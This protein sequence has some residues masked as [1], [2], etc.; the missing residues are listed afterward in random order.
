MP[1]LMPWTPPLLTTPS[2]WPLSFGL[3]QWRT[4]GRHTGWSRP[5]QAAPLLNLPQPHRLQRGLRSQWSLQNPPC[6]T[7]CCASQPSKLSVPWP[8][9]TGASPRN[10]LNSSWPPVLTHQP[11]DWGGIACMEL[12]DDSAAGLQHLKQAAKL[13][14]GNVRALHNLALGMAMDGRVEGVERLLATVAN[15]PMRAVS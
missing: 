6:L 15:L 3:G 10:A 11:A 1:L 12:G 5:H 8:T 4:C 7:D 14:G 9:R 2:W 13:S